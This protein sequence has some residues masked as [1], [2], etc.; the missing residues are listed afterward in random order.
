MEAKLHVLSLFLLV[1]CHHGALAVCPGDAAP[2][3]PLRFGFMTA[4]DPRS[5]YVLAGIIPSVNLAL[6]LINNSTSILPGYN[7]S[8]NAGDGVV[9]DSGVSCMEFYCA[10]VQ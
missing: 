10:V 8:Y 6:E 2:P 3:V 4:V 1:L 5:D 9:Y 7:L